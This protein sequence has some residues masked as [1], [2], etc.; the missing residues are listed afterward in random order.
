MDA[1]QLFAQQ[2]NVTVPQTFA[3]TSGFKVI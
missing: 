1:V 3:V 2:Q